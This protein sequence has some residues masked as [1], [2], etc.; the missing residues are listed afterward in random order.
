LIVA[1][2]NGLTNTC[3]GVVTATAGTNIVSLAGGTVAAA[4]S[5]TL[6]VT[7][8]GPLG[9]YTNTTGAVT[10]TNGGTGNT[11]SATLLIIPPGPVLTITPIQANVTAFQGDTATFAITMNA[12]VPLGPVTFS[13]SGQPAGTNCQ[14]SAPPA[15]PGSGNVL[16]TIT[17][18]RNTSALAVPPG[19]S[20]PSPLYAAL[21]LPVLGLVAAGLSKQNRKKTML[22]FAMALSG[23]AV[24]MALAGCGGRHDNGTVPGVYNITV[25]ANSASAQATSNVILT[26]LHR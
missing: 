26:V 24:A 11:A 14:F 18:F 4:S 21:F 16:M 13:C 2:P 1:T 6:T 23:L 8:T 25:T 3:G 15:T 7:V 22:R 17:T 19:G 12:T 10:S 5:C 20:G 9:I